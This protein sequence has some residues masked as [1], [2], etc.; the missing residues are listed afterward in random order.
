MCPFLI[1]VGVKNHFNEGT[2]ISEAG[3]GEDMTEEERDNYLHKANIL[4]FT[5]LCVRGLLCILS[6]ANLIS[7]KIKSGNESNEQRDE[8]EA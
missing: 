1:K 5:A 4:G 2:Q 6:A 3:L 7:W 8:L